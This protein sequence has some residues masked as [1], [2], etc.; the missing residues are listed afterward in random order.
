MPNGTPVDSELGIYPASMA[1]SAYGRKLLYEAFHVGI[2]DEANSW[3]MDLWDTKL[4]AMLG[5]CS[6]VSDVKGVT[7]GSQYVLT[8][9]AKCEWAN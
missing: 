3:V 2:A 8:P 6:A 9:V 1:V 5:Q 4:G 7:C